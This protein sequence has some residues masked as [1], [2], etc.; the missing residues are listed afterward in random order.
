MSVNTVASKRS[1]DYEE[2]SKKARTCN[3][4]L[5]L[6]DELWSNIASYL[7]KSDLKN[8]SQVSQFDQAIALKAL[9]PLE[10]TSTKNQIKALHDLHPKNTESISAPINFY[11]TTLLD[12]HA[13]NQFVL[14]SHEKKKLKQKLTALSS[15]HA[16]KELKALSHVCF[17]DLTK[18][19]V[20][21]KDIESVFERKTHSLVA[22][23][24]LEIVS[25]LK[26]PANATGTIFKNAAAKGHLEIV[27]AFMSSGNFTPDYTINALSAAAQHGH[28]NIIEF[29]LETTSVSSYQKTQPLT[30]AAKYGH[31]QIVKALLTG[32]ACYSAAKGEAIHRASEGGYLEILNVLLDQD[33]HKDWI[34]T[35]VIGASRNGHL[36]IVRRLLCHGSISA[37]HRQHARYFA[38]ENG[39][40]EIFELLESRAS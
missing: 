2:T 40:R 23:A 21:F 16:A 19:K 11:K 31:L 26:N 6:P 20:F 17:E 32:D 39:Y 18:K 7:N 12:L 3:Q 4:C 13:N 9:I 29:F 22:Q 33:V 1:A 10:E 27:K 14:S 28:L 38:R 34:G 30:L 35:A 15:D 24:L 5:N 36:V 25:S 37:E 8:L